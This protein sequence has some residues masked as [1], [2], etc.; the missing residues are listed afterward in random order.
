LPTF[1]LTFQG[2]LTTPP[3]SEDATWMVLKTQ[4]KVVGE[5]IAAFGKI[6]P[7]N[8]RPTQPGNGRAIR[9]TN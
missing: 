5:E 3:C 1:Y 4:I 6:Y 8:A 7:M 2:S 9:A